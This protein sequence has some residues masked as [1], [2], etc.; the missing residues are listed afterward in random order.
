[1]R[2]VADMSSRTAHGPGIRAIRESLGISLRALASDIG[3][4]PAHLSHVERGNRAA[5]DVLIASIARRLG[6]TV[7]AIT[8]PTSGRA[9]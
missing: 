6:V 1:M 4:S 2:I 3:V 5:S 9:A 8:Y 7:D